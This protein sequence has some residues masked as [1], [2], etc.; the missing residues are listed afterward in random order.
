MGKHPIGFLYRIG[1]K[2]EQQKLWCLAYAFVFPSLAVAQNVDSIRTNI[3]VQRF[4]KPV[5]C[6][7][8]SI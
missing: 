2:R 1:K 6:C 4:S 5:S 7:D 3:A 8:L